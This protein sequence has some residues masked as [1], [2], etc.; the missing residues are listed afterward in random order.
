MTE[1]QL[2]THGDQTLN[3]AGACVPNPVLMAASAQLRVMR[4]TWQLQQLAWLQSVHV[5]RS[6][7]SR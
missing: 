3:A 7:W 2:E 6:M 4:I 1:S 5:A